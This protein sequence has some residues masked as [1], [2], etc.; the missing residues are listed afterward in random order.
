MPNDSSTGGFIPP[1][2]S[3]APLVD[4]ALDALL[5]QLVVGITGLPGNMVRPRWQ[6][7]VPQQPDPSTNWCAIGVIDIDADDFPA[8]TH[9]SAGNGSDAQSDHETLTVMAS[10]YG[11]N[12][13]GNAKMLR[14]GLYVLQNLD[15]LAANGMALREAKRIVTAPD[16]LNQQWIRRY[17]L[18][19]ILRRNSVYSYPILNLLSGP[20]TVSSDST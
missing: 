8:E 14:S 1:A 11:P 16:F 10:F 13:M 17:D 5:Q 15:T 19:V 3:P 9:I 4:A 20:F 6:P 2:S 12:G 7:I 18:T